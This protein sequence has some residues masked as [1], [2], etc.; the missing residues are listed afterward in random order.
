MDYQGV[1][2]FLIKEGFLLTALEFHVELSEK[3]QILQSLSQFFQDTKNFE[4]FTTKKSPSSSVCGSSILDENSLFDLTRNSEDFQDDSKLAVLEFELRKARETIFNLREELTQNEKI[5]DQEDEVEDLNIKSHEKKILNF[6]INEYLLQQ[7]YKLTSITFSEE[8]NDADYF[9][10]W[11]NIGINAKPPNLLK[12]Y[13]D[14]GKHFNEESVKKDAEINTDPDQEKLNL[15]NEFQEIHESFTHLEMELEQT[16][17]ELSQ[18][19]CDKIR[20]ETQ[21]KEKESVIEILRCNDN[22]KNWKN[23]EIIKE[24]SDILP[25][26]SPQNISMLPLITLAIQ[27]NADL[28][29]REQLINLMFNLSKKPDFDQRNLICQNLLK[30][31]QVVKVEEEILPLLCDGM[32][33]KLWERRLLVCEISAVLLPFLPQNLTSSLILSMMQQLATQDSIVQVREAATKTLSQLIPFCDFDKHKNLEDILE[34]LQN[35]ANYKV[36]LKSLAEWYLDENRHENVMNLGQKCMKSSKNIDIMVK[37]MQV[38]LPLILTMLEKRHKEELSNI[39]S[40]EWFETWPELEWFKSTWIS[41]MIQILGQTTKED[42][43]QISPIFSRFFVD[44]TSKLGP[45][46]TKNEILPLFNSYLPHQSQ[47]LLT[48]EEV[49][50]FSSCLFPIYVESLLSKLEHSKDFIENL[51]NFAIIYST[52]SQLNSWPI[53]ASIELIFSQNGDQQDNEDAIA[54]LSWTLVVYPDSKVKIL[55]SQTLQS[56]A[57]KPGQGDLVGHKILPGLVTL[58][59]D[60]EPLVRASALMGLALIVISQ[61][62]TTETRE[63]AA[64]QLISFINPHHEKVTTV[65]K[66]K[67]SHF[68]NFHFFFSTE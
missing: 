28:K 46:F 60:P 19:K 35:D 39:L 7:N 55:A 17:N 49:K 11:D 26:I 16:R 65:K 6:V 25:Q 67:F 15:Q 8:N 9:E 31:A 50:I 47:K 2:D 20:F 22:G 68:P 18:E 53:L 66:I 62:S 42:F 33:H 52:H 59:S 3:G 36:F 40:K 24:L 41:E 58:S 51:Q 1:A 57:L 27:N 13:K 56:L 14:F 61:K 38:L 54:E 44:I 10:D 63:K 37:N 21:L 43:C 23:L 30:I 5:Q 32:E 48:E 4:S 29:I 12:L 34:L 64:F 45:N